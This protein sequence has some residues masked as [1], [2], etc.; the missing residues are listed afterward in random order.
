M[1]FCFSFGT[2]E[3][4]IWEMEMEFLPRRNNRSS[5]LIWWQ[6]DGSFSFDEPMGIL[7]KSRPVIYP[8]STLK[9]LDSWFHFNL[10]NYLGQTL[11]QQRFYWQVWLQA[12]F[13]PP[14]ILD[15]MGRAIGI[16]YSWSLLYNCTESFYFI[17]KLMYYHIRTKL[18]WWQKAAKW[19]TDNNL[20]VVDIAFK[21]LTNCV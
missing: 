8:D 12:Y 7:S 10:W 4:T 17:L 11:L 16:F 18:L 3:N 20:F 6:R 14:E 2:K 1:H 19:G 9:V 13:V 15:S 5:N 21:V